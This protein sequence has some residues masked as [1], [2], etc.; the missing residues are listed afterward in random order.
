[1]AQESP[2]DSIQGIKFI[3]SEICKEFQKID[4]V[5]VAYLIDA[6]IE[7]IDKLFLFIEFKG[8][9]IEL[10]QGQLDWLK[11]S[12]KTQFGDF[13]DISNIFIF[14]ELPKRIKSTGAIGVDKEQLYQLV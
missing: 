8:E 3:K 11:E 7:T 14:K 2:F 10:V 4:G 13:F 12:V 1:M 5:K 6:N 9:Q